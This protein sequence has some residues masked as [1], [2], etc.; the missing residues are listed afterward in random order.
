MASNDSGVQETVSVSKNVTED[1]Q[2]FINTFEVPRFCFHVTSIGFST[3]FCH[4]RCSLNKDH[5]NFTGSETAWK[6]CLRQGKVM[7]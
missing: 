3:G 1:G 2:K 5:L 6:G 7:P 4:R